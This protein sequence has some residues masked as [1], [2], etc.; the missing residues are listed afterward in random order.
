MRAYQ[1]ATRTIIEIEIAETATKAAIN[2][3][4]KLTVIEVQKPTTSKIFFFY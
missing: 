1:Q 3:A 2:A 4:A